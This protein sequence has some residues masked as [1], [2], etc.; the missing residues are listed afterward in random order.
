MGTGSTL[1][2]LVLLAHIIVAV[3]GFGGLFTHTLYTARALRMPAEPAR[4][5][6]GA[7]ASAAKVA[8]Y[9]LYALLAFG[10]ALVALSDGAIG[11][12]ATWISASFVVWFVI[13]GAAHGLVRPT[14]AR[15]QERAEALADDV[16]TGGS[17]TLADDTEAI[18]L[19]GRLRAGDGLIE[20]LLLV[21]LGL[22]IWQPG[23]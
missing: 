2:R 23:G 3:V 9:A 21:A 1:Y 12:G 16:A 4:V 19:T 13:V 10:I 18:G 6:L 22:M 5:V 15:L 17:R 20:L 7:T 8:H 14:I 11:F